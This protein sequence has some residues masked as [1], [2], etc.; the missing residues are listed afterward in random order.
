[1]FAQAV[2]LSSPRKSAPFVAINF[3]ALPDSLV[4]SELFGYEEGAFTGARK[5]GKPGLFEDA[6]TGTIFLDEIGDASPEVQKRLLR[7]LEEKEIRRVGSGTIIPIDVRVIAATNQDLHLLVKQGKFRQDL[8]YRLCTV[9]IDV[10]SLSERTEDIPLLI[11][12]FA[13]K[14]YQRE[15]RLDPEAFDFLQN[16]PWPGNVRELQNIVNFICGVNDSQDVIRMRNLPAY[17]VREKST[18]AGLEAGPQELETRT[19]KDLLLEFDRLGARAH[20][21]VMI[22]TYT[23][24]AVF[25]R[26][27]GRQMLIRALT[28]NSLTCPEH[29]VRLLLKRLKQAGC[30][31]IGKTRQGSFLTSTGEQLKAYMEK[32][33]DQMR[34]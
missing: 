14:H 6:H 4:E 11:R 17:L 30:I 22:D 18:A 9:T 2:H 24:H 13:K 8:Y 12:F 21:K 7:V 27:V 28:Q 34:P 16:Y 29:K 32:N 1:L 23:H 10:P 31:T 25:D 5:G 26:G 33:R 15:I 3:A 19:L 20:L